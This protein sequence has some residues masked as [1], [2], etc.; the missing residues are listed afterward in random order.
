M[1]SSR[2]LFLFVYFVLL[3]ESR[4]RNLPAQKPHIVFIYADDLGWNDVG[5]HNPTIPTPHLNKLASEGV[6]LNSMY[7]QPTC[8]PSRVSLLTGYYPFH[9]ELQKAVMPVEA[10]YL[11]D[12]Y[13]LLPQYL[14]DLG[15]TTHMIGKWHLGFCNEKYTPTRRGFDSFYGILS[16]SN[17]HYTHELGSPVPV[18]FSNKLF[19][20]SSIKGSLKSSLKVRVQ[21][22]FQG[23][24]FRFNET[25]WKD[26]LRMYSTHAYTKRAVDII[27]RHDPSTPLFMYMSY[28]APHMP[29]DVPKRYADKFRHVEMQERRKYLGMVSAIDESVGAITRALRTSK[30]MNNLLLIFT[31]DNGG[32]PYYGGN[33]WPLRGAKTSNWEGGTRVPTFVYSETLLHRK[34]ATTNEMMH[35]IDWMP[36]LLEVAGRKPVYGIDGRSQWR[37][38]SRGTLSS[39]EELVYNIEPN[40]GKGAIRVGDYKLLIG[41]PGMQNDWYPPPEDTHEPRMRYSGGKKDKVNVKSEH[42]FLYNIKDDPFEIHNLYKELPEVAEVLLSRFRSYNNTRKAPLERIIDPASNPENFGGFWSPGWC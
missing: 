11:P 21:T 35:M 6:I 20:N 4:K 3:A 23:V 16:G 26:D 8:T 38:I 24:D 13:K 40:S 39:R 19:L 14:K 36:T 1:T 5:W 37:M 12:K 10:L 27:R 7:A 30:L 9:T 34:K 18:S 33:N 32:N 15:Y 2:S 31:S 42:F 22:Y 25:S 17:D 29:I 28:Q 41:K